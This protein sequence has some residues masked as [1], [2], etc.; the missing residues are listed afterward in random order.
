MLAGTPATRTVIRTALARPVPAVTRTATVTRTVTETLS[1]D[2]EG[3]PFYRTCAEAPG[4]I[5][6][7]MPGY[8]EV[9]DED[10]DGIACESA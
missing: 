7:G 5:E 4:P 10:G 3:R 6:R 2:A 1:V 9:L 8:R